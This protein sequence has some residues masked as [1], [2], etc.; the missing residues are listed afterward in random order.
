MP[1]QVF[2]FDTMLLIAYLKGEKER[3][4]YKTAKDIIG[5]LKGMRA[6]GHPIEVRISA[7]V[8]AE[9]I[10]K[11]R[12]QMK[13]LQEDLLGRFLKLINELNIE[14][15][16]PNKEAIECA[17]ELLNEDTY[18]KPTDAMIVAQFLTE[19]MAESVTLYTVDKDLY[20]SRAIMD[21]LD[22]I[23]KIKDS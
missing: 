13:D 1:D 19:R 23:H 5:K 2:Y 7:L 12:E 22:K 10:N 16:F 14:I 17:R 9:V 18:L 21:R 4:L 6:R 3:D 15:T 20:N 11:F 8:V